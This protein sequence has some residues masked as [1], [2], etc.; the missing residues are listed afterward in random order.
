MN[1]RR[2]F[3]AGL[4]AVTARCSFGLSLPKIEALPEPNAFAGDVFFGERGLYV[5]THEEYTLA[6]AFYIN[7][8]TTQRFIEDGTLAPLENPT[9][10]F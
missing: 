1:S 2:A 3:L 6:N 8:E 9:N 5:M 4:V 10:D 7:E